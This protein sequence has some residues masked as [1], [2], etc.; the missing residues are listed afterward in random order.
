VAQNA[1][2]SFALDKS[3]PYVYLKFD[4]VADRKPLSPDEV[5]KGL[6]LR[7]VNNCR[8]PII[9]AVFNPGTTDVGTG[10]FDEVVPIEDP[11]GVP[12]A[13]PTQAS[14]PD[15]RARPPEGYSSEVFSTRTI[16]PGADLLFS[17]PVNHVSPSWYLQI[18]FN[19]DALGTTYGSEPYSVVSFH[20]QDIP[21]KVRVGLHP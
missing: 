19:L 1:D 2:R 3:K 15:Q 20:W 6:W 18:I 17:V 9:V 16:P 12:L 5:S 14:K 10:V 7:L 8:L 11:K 4:H 13:G 21:E